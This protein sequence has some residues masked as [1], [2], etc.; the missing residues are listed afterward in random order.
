[1]SDET[2]HFAAYHNTER[3]GR[4]LSA[5]NPL[6]VLTN[7]SVD[8]LYENVVWMVVGE[9]KSTRQFS[10]GSVFCVTETGDAAED[11]FKHFAAGNGHVFE[12]TIPLNDLEWFKDFKASMNSFQF[13]V[14]PVKDE[15]H[16]EALKATCHPSWRS[17][18]LTYH[19]T[20]V[21]VG[22][23]KHSRSSL[24]TDRL[25]ANFRPLDHSFSRLVRHIFRNRTWCYN[26]LFSEGFGMTTVNLAP[27]SP[28]STSLDDYLPAWTLALGDLQ[29][30]IPELAKDPERLSE[31]DSV[32]GEIP[33]LH[34]SVHGDARDLAGIEPNSV[35]LVLT[36]PPYWTLKEYRDSDGQMGHLED[37]DHFPRVGRGLAALLRRARPRGQTN[38]RRR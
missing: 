34:R 24:A 38:L 8:L 30:A 33:T 37:Y 4:P 14:Q 11:G 23:N 36:S 31:L 27:F 18:A 15:S 5:G 2:Q 9:G 28:P 10:L 16:I 21:A 3:M 22:R 7:K 25:F 32:I 35:H 12:P 20:G 29:T 13:G 17:R 1:M 19:S 6:Q 26:Q